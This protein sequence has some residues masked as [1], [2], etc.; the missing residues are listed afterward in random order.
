MHGLF[1]VFDISEEIT[2]Y[3]RSKFS[4]LEAFCVFLKRFAYPFRYSDLVPRFGRPVPEVCMMSKYVMNMLHESFHHL[5]RSFNQPL[6]SQQ[7]LELYAHAVHDKGA[8]LR[9]CWGFV[10][11]TI[12]PICRPSDRTQ[13]TLCNGQKRVHALKFQSIVAPNRLIA[14]LYGTVERRRHDSGI[15]AESNLLPL[16]QQRCHIA[17]GSP[18]YIY[19]DPAC[20]LRAHLQRLLEVNHLPQEQKDFNKSMKTVRVSLEWEFN[21]IIR[22]F[23]FMHFKKTGRY[24]LGPLEK[25]TILVHF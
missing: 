20:R 1:K 8:A 25:C 16:L 9:N 24:N 13:I 21:E 17:N 10:E 19:G 18:L 5:L 22:Y 4:G 12:R 2:C 3:N 6:L 15:L 14:N 7:D 23:A 11:E